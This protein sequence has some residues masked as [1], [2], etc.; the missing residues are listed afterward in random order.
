MKKVFLMLVMLFTMSVCSFAEDNNATETQR[1]E[2]YDI[3]VNTK[4]LAD[5]LELTSDQF[6]AVECIADQ[7]SKDMMFAAIECESGNCKTVTKNVLDKNI[8]DMSYVLNKEQYHKYLK[9][10]NATITNRKI[11]Y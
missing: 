1:I 10:L 4:K 8:K 11:E 2:R 6:E 3:K 7:F 5:Y 9:V